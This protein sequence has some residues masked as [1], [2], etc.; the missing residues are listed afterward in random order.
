VSGRL[1]VAF[2]ASDSNRLLRSKYHTLC[3]FQ[4]TT[5]VIQHTTHFA[6]YPLICCD[7][8][9]VLIVHRYQV[10]HSALGAAPLLNIPLSLCLSLLVC[11]TSSGR[12]DLE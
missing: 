1:L 10:C 3:N 9:C 12:M 8:W 4:F 7:C 2:I 5:A 6:M 11:R